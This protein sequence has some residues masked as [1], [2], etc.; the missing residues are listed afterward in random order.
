[1]PAVMPGAE[2]F[3][4]A[5]N[6]TGCLL[7]HGFMG[8]PNEMRELGAHLH[9]QGF[10][11]LGARLAGHGT[12]VQEMNRTTWQDW[13][14]SLEVAWD[15]LDA[16]CDE[17]FVVGLSLGAAL[18]LHLA[19]HKPV[20]GVAVMGAPVLSSAFQR[21]VVGLGGRLLPVL[22]KLGGSGLR[23][24]VAKS[25]HLTYPR[26]PMRASVSMIQ[27][28]QVAHADLSAITAPILLMQ[29]R[30]D[31]VVSTRNMSYIYEHVGSTDKE[32]VWLDRSDHIVTEDYDRQEVFE[33]LGEWIRQRAAGEPSQK[34]RD[35]LG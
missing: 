31:R 9:A 5:G 15:E 18:T 10:T 30:Q 35:A 26:I 20:A 29:G 7:S 21:A 27:L 34:P 28:V 2:P 4:F 25:Q 22:P 12:T 33:R 8:T 16:G 23:D 24:P 32:M 17:V 14:A 19:A 1:M 6:R 13:Y 3:F 11:V